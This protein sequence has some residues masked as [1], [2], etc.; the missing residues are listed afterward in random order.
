MHSNVIKTP[1]PGLKSLRIYLYFDDITNTWHYHAYMAS[2]S[3]FAKIIDIPVH[4]FI[5]TGPPLHPNRSTP[6]SVDTIFCF[7]ARILN[8]KSWYWF[9]LFFYLFLTKL[10]VQM[11]IWLRIERNI[12]P[13][14]DLRLTPAPHPRITISWKNEHQKSKIQNFKIFI[15][16]KVWSKWIRRTILRTFWSILD[17]PQN[18][19]S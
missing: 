5:E 2:K 3:G 19:V 14:G 6:S 18:F 1:S 9:W 4:P 10:D 11:W 15:F 7:F 12:F 8:N 16:W 13:A 17:F